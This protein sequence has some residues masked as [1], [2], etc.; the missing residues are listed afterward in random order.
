MGS[1]SQTHN[2]VET[3]RAHRTTRSF[4]V[5]GLFGGIGGLEFG[6]SQAGHRT[7]SF[8]EIDPEAATILRE[9]FPEAAMTRDIRRTNEVCSSVSAKSD[10][11]T[12][13]FPCTDLSQA[14]RVQGFAGGRSSLIHY[15]L[16]ILKSR[17]FAHVLL[18]NVPNWRR[19]HSGR[20]LAEVVGALE[21]LGY[22]WA[23][24]TIDALAFGA[25]QRRLR[26]FL[27]A[28]LEGDPRGVLFHGDHTPAAPEFGLSERAHGFYWTE[29]TRGLGWGE[30][31]VPPLKGGSTVGV[32]APPAILLPSFVGAAAAT[33]KG[34]FRVITPNVQDAERLQGF[35]A[36]WTAA[37]AETI[38]GGHFQQRRRWLMIGNSVNVRA[39]AWLGAQLG[40]PTLWVGEEGTPL[41][42]GDS[43]P[44]AAWSDGT[45]RYGAA[46]GAW[47]VEAPRE[48]LTEFL[49]HPG[50]PLSARATV[51]FLRRLLDSRLRVRKGFVDELQHHLLRLEGSTPCKAHSQDRASN[52]TKQ[53]VCRPKR[54]LRSLD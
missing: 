54:R 43:W 10:L 20:Y 34:L 21:A 47:P 23:Y 18:E 26:I 35:P 17:P 24:R 2:S 19:L 49:T 6:L 1:D 30:D 14:G 46:V 28:T 31:C 25:P 8:C 37:A 52:A 36:G 38:D 12:A 3:L 39:A 9:R 48:T 11:L 41:E 16:R 7:S 50:A 5:T 42:G 33:S 45:N 13:G 53:L 22:R 15:A 32:P 29:G 27:Y 44:A 51:G 40:T 4:D